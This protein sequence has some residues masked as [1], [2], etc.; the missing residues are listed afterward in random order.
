MMEINK[1]SPGSS[2]R[3]NVVIMS[4]KGTKNYCEYDEKSET[5]M[6]KKVLHQPF[7]GF[8]GIIPQTHHV[9]AGPLDA[10]VLSNEHIDQGIVIQTRPIGLIRLSGNIPD[11]ILITVLIDDKTVEKT[12][13]LL[14][15]DE[16][17]LDKLKNFLEDLKGKKV[18]DIFGADRARK[19]FER[20][21]ELYK[22]EFE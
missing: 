10:I 22:K 12:Q 7:P 3:I 1:L 14:T 19:S 13:D 17:E 8:Y 20:A 4:E 6:L 2:D 21:V 15:L 16:E 11:Y 5:F 18:Q 9:D